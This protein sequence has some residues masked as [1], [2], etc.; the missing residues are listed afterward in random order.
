MLVS[1]TRHNRLMGTPGRP[2]RTVTVER[3]IDAPPELIFGLLADPSQHHR[4]DGSGMLH[5]RARGPERLQLGAKF[6]MAMQQSRVRYRSLNRVVEFDENRSIAWETV[7]ERNGRRFIGGQRWRYQL[8]PIAG[9]DGLPSTLVLHSYDWGA[10]MFAPAIR[11]GGYPRRMAV[12]MTKTLQRLASAISQD[13][14]AA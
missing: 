4:I 1:V 12:G 7:G 2:D 5:G 6:S 9:P 3:T 10:A 13:A 8:V 11:L 14:S